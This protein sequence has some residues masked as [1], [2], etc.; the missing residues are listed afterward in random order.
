MNNYLLDNQFLEELDNY[1]QR[2]LYVKILAL[3]LEEDPIDEI[4]G[5]VTGGSISVDGASKLRRSCSLT[6]ISQQ[7]DINEYLWCLNTKIRVSIG[8]RNFIN[9]SVYGEI[10]WFPQGTFVLN[11]FN[12]SIN[13]TSSTI[14]IQGKD[15][16]CLLNGDV[17]GN[18]TALSY[19][20]DIV[21]EENGYNSY[22][23]RKLPLHYIIREAVHTFANEPYH[24]I[25]I[26]DLDEW[27]LELLTYRGEEP[28]YFV[29]SLE[30]E[31]ITNMTVNK[32]QPYEYNGSEKTIE[33]L[34]RMEGFKFK[35]LNDFISQTSE[36]ASIVY[37]K[38]QYGVRKAFQ[39]IRIDYGMTCGYR[40][41]DLVYVSDLVLNVGD[42]LTAMLDKVVSMLGNFEYFY[43]LEGQFIFQ[44][45]RTY[46][47][48]SWN[49][50][51]NNGEEQWAESAA[52]TSDYTYSLY[53]SKL[54]SSFSNAP[55]LNNVKNDFS[56]WGTKKGATGIDLPIHMRY[57]IDK[58][59]SY[60]TTADGSI[61]YT[62]KTEAQVEEDKQS[63]LLELLGKGYQKE[64]SRFGLSEDWWEV[65]DWAK[66]WEFSGLP[67]PT[68]NLGTYCPVRVIVYPEGSNPTI[69]NSY[70][71]YP[72]YQVPQSIWE[73]WG[74][75]SI[76]YLITEDI[77][78]HGDGTY[79]DHHGL[80][81]HSY[82]EWLNY[83]SDSGRYSGGYAYFYKPQ[84]PAED[85]K[86]NGGQGLL[87]GTQIIYEADWRELIYQMALDHNKYGN[88]DNNN[89]K[90]ILLKAQQRSDSKYVIVTKEKFENSKNAYIEGTEREV[91]LTTA[92]RE[93]NP[94]FYPS[95]YTGY[96][97][98]YIDMLGFWRQIYDPE[99]ECS[100]EIEPITK[101]E[102]EAL[103]EEGILFYDA[104]VYEACT[105]NSIFYDNI[106]YYTKSG[107]TYTVALMLTEQEFNRGKKSGKYYYIKDVKIQP[108][109]I[110]TEPINNNETYYKIGDYEK[111]ATGRELNSKAKD[112]KLYC[113]RIPN[114]K[115]ILVHKLEPFHRAN[116]Y[117]FYKTGTY[118]PPPS[119]I[120][121]G[122][123]ESRPWYYNRVKSGVQQCCTSIAISKPQLRD[124]GC[125]FENRNR[126]KITKQYTINE[127]DPNGGSSVDRSVA[128]DKN[129][130]NEDLETICLTKVRS[131][132]N[133]G[134]LAQALD[135]IPWYYCYTSYTYEPLVHPT[136]EFD[137][138]GTYYLKSDIKEFNSKDDK[139]PYWK[140]DLLTNPE[141]LIFWF[142]FLDT[143]GEMES[144]SVKR[145]GDR[146]KAVND[147][148]VK[149]IYFRETPGVLFLH[150]DE[151]EE[152][153]NGVDAWNKPTGYAYAQ[154]PKYLQHLFTISSQGKSAKDVL[155]E[156]LYQ[157]S[158]CTETITVSALP[159]Y[160]LEP[161][162]RVLIRDDNSHINGEYVVNKLTIPLDPKGSMTINAIKAIDRLY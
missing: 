31:D 156:Y 103:R 68:K 34:S 80:C 24:N 36:Q 100:Y 123:Y 118:Y 18:L 35:T 98:Y 150:P 162:T 47:H 110:T 152:Y 55:A 82:T 160:H 74:R 128:C 134:E 113:K 21:E 41:T 129:I 61:T 119:G 159:I 1:K 44:K 2:E 3:T 6:L 127:P 39:L 99:Y 56:I 145:I 140:A 70:K 4:Q 42:G 101:I 5:R 106:D 19:A 79:W 157:Y 148:D 139:P 28:M 51:K 114:E 141:G 130:T 43:N 64:P 27:G 32:E 84:V 143:E 52:H 133:L 155:D 16:M 161:N 105:E 97:Q 14:S 62:T 81:A 111:T 144:Y 75:N 45:K 116:L 78:F 85:L 151:W 13:N 153:S 112:P 104:P 20:F 142:D 58:K 67:V 40:I 63:G 88:I 131:C 86:E 26:N 93:Q 107:N 137:S 38:D 92:I 10:V 102:Y 124:S 136:L 72:H 117:N 7:L 65:R 158:Y 138:K 125:W 71:D 90:T 87:L 53:N 30:D 33:Q 154:V 25:I 147:K 50:L 96:E 8:M 77:I 49:N 60:Y 66:A 115:R 59:P 94:T 108:V 126:I 48:T 89:P 76:N 120:T 91:S 46:I 23:K 122:D 109:P 135:D 37:A 132:N 9:P 149:A 95:G 29:Y 15:K 11:S 146:P 22:Y 12:I 83:F 54:V 57:A 121:K 17:G 69:H 73:S